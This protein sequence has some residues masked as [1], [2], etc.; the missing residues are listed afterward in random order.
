ME[1]FKQSARFFYNSSP[2][3]ITD[4]EGDAEFSGLLE[5]FIHHAR[6]IHDICIYNNQDVYAKF[7]LTYNP[8][9][10]IS[11]KIVIGGGK[12]P[13]FNEKLVMKVTQLDSVLKCE[14][15]MLSRV[16]N[17]IEDQLLCFTLVPISMVAGK[18]ELTHDFSLSSTDLFHSPAG[19][20]LLSLSLNTTAP[21]SSSLQP[22]SNSSRNSSIASEVV[23]FDRKQSEIISDMDEYSRIEF[24]DINAVQEN[25]K[26]V[27]EYFSLAMDGS[28]QASSGILSSTATSMSDDRNTADST[29]NKPAEANHKNAST[30]PNTPTS[31]K[32]AEAIKDGRDLYYLTEKDEK[33][34]DKSGRSS[35]FPG[36]FSAPLDM[37]VEAE[38]SAMQ[39]QIVDMY[40]KSMQQFTES[41]AK[42]K[43]PMDLDKPEAEERVNGFHKQSNNKSETDKKKDGSRVFYGSGAFF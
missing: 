7:S 43:L 37:N 25:Q 21:L 8:D 27:S 17:L 35:R 40:M 33:K 5:I 6:N 19:T 10:T 28:I 32:G 23:L 26:M 29:E 41:L 1:S 39:Q 22:Y 14:I 12:N 36:V 34:Q 30:L 11:T 9:E 13:D 2:D 3:V 20:V 42:M 16:R 4:S 38:Q 31:K 18:G 15:W 24:P